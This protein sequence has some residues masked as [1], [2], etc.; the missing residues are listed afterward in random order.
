MTKVD[1]VSHPSRPAGGR[2]AV[3]SWLAEQYVCV[4][5][6]ASDKQRAL[7]ETRRYSTQSLASVAYLINS[8]AHNLLHTLH[9]QDTQ[10]IHLEEAVTHISQVS[11]VHKRTHSQENATSIFLTIICSDTV[12]SEQKA[13]WRCLELHTHSLP[14][15]HK[16]HIYTLC[17]PHYSA[18]TAAIQLAKLF[19]SNDDLVLSFMLP[20]TVAIPLYLTLPEWKLWQN[21]R[22]M[23][24]QM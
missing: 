17:C 4:F 18:V 22:H 1:K 11:T 6:Q 10:L 2:L 12:L 20:F 9:N 19:L 16:K 14:L 24:D 3:S 23:L 21:Q 13:I 5:V 7:E 15:T 8:L